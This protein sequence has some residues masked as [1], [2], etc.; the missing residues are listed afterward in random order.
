MAHD[1]QLWLT[2]RLQKAAALCNQTPAASDT[3]LWLGVDLGTCN[4]VSMVVD[5]NAQPVAVCLDWADVV[6]DGIVWDFFGAVT[7][8]CRH[9]DTLEQQLGCR[10]THAATSFPPGTDPRISINV[11]ESAGLEV[12]HVLDEPTAVADL[13]ALDNAGVVDIGGGT[14][15]IAIVKQGKVTY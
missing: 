2:P 9:L 6:R 15:G 11:L 14:T 12:S 4:V 7:L 13:L 5:G 10:F 3:P 8:V 1:E